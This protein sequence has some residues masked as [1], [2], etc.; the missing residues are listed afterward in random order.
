[1]SIVKYTYII[2]IAVLCLI[3]FIIV[4]CYYLLIRVKKIGSKADNPPFSPT[5]YRLD[6]LKNLQFY[7]FLTFVE[8]NE[9]TNYYEVDF[10]DYFEKL[11]DNLENKKIVYYQ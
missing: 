2:T 8:T 7:P 3:L 9:Y 5:Q 4:Y 6:Y 11:K 10:D 1:M